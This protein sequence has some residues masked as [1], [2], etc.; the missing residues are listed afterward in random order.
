M[1]LIGA[2]TWAR[3]ATLCVVQTVGAIIA[4]YM[5][6]AIFPGG[7]NVGTALHP[8]VSL[9]QGVIIEMLLTA[10]LVFT[11]F[12]L[13]AEKHDATFIA[14]VC[15]GL[16]LFIAELIG[17]P[18]SATMSS[19]RKLTHDFRCALDR[20][21]L[22]PGSF[23]RSSHRHTKLPN[24]PLDLLGWAYVRIDYCSVTLQT[25]QGIGV[26]DRARR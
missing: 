6:S 7:L 14:P 24:V 9:A 23:S 26:R 15:I 11:I 8:E 21:V 25:H 19:F 4:A 10:Q 18:P 16:S 5:V 13:A 2:L 22:E 12:M 3:V 17:K 20:W 1:G